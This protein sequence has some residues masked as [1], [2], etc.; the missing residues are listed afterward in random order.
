[1]SGLPFNGTA[2]WDSL[3][4]LV[5]RERNWLYRQRHPSHSQRITTSGLV[6]YRGTCCPSSVAHMPRYGAAPRIRT[7]S[8]TTFWDMITIISLRAYNEKDLKGKERVVPPGIEIPGIPARKLVMV[9]ES[10]SGLALG[11]A[12]CRL[13]AVSHR[14]DGQGRHGDVG[15]DGIHHGSEADDDDRHQPYP[16]PAV[17]PLVTHAHVLRLSFGPRRDWRGS[18]ARR[19]PGGRFSSL[20]QDV[21]RRRQSYRL[22][23]KR[24]R[25]RC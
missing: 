2:V 24:R 3:S 23:W 9:C 8:I 19:M 14:P 7:R 25:R 5:R 15:R 18:V 10:P 22:R 17:R 13:A 1:M 21:H 11:R 4:H 20:L 6:E 12:G 16:G